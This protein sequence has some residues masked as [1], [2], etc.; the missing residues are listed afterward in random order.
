M[1]NFLDDLN[2]GLNGLAG[3]VLHAQQ[4][5]AMLKQPNTPQATAQAATLPYAQQPQPQ[6]QN[7][8]LWLAGGGILLALVWVA[9]K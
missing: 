4:L 8:L 3:T 2:A 6:K 1:A 5:Q 7:W 9:K